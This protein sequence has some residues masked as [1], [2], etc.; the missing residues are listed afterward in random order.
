MT[1]YRSGN[2]VRSH[3]GWRQ[4]VSKNGAA[5]LM[6][7]TPT[8]STSPTSPCLAVQVVFSRRWGVPPAVR[9]NPATDA[10]VPRSAH[11]RCPAPAKSSLARRAYPPE[12]TP[13]NDRM[14]AAD[15]SPARPREQRAVRRSPVGGGRSSP[16]ETGRNRTDFRLARK[17]GA[18]LPVSYGLLGQRQLYPD[19]RVLAMVSYAD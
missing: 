18:A 15:H 2:G 4:P 19:R 17:A 3:G 16:E 8:D 10:E 7:N 6:C 12:R 9:T 14:F 1:T 11:R 13:V 5:S